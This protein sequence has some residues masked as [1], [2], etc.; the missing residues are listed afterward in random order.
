MSP[1]FTQLPGNKTAVKDALTGKVFHTH[2]VADAADLALFLNYLVE[3][4][5]NEQ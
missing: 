4:H 2:S 3:Q 5:P 1:R